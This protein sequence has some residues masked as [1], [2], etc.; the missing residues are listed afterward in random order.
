VLGGELFTILRSQTLF[1]EKT[2]RFYAACVLSAFE[3][4]HD[5]DIIYR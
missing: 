1:D 5:Q 2:A 4:M 3:Y